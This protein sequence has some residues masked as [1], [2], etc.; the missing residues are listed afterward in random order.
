MKI[1]RNLIGPVLLAII[2]L[3][4]VWG[5]LIAHMK[6][7]AGTN[8]AGLPAG[9]HVWVLRTA[10]G[11]RL[12]GEKIWGYHRLGY[13]TP[14]AGDAVLFNLPSANGMSS[15][16]QKVAGVCRNVPGDTVW[17]DP[18]RKLILPG[19]TSPDALPITVPASGESVRIAPHNARLYASI[20]RLHEKKNAKVDRRKRLY[21]NGKECDSV[22]FARDY[23]WIETLPDSF[24]LVPHEALIG[25]IV[26]M[27]KE[28][29]KE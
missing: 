11:L 19:R 24:L 5:L 9:Q 12:P 28:T 21:L 18:L 26:P 7:P 4:A 6:I 27:R 13:K 15:S 14:Q 10:Y 8:V 1:L 2:L 23:Y 17:T 16:G 25:K 20:M 29:G 3:L 22:T